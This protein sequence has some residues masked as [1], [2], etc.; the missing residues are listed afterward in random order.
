MAEAETAHDMRKQEYHQEA[1][2][3]QNITEAEALRKS[4]KYNKQLNKEH[5][6]K[7]DKKHIN[8]LEVL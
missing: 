7:Y 1:M 6:K 2:Q 4:N 8:M 3:R 5:N